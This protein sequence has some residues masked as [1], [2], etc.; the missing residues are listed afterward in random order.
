MDLRS[1]N[2]IENCSLLNYVK[3]CLAIKEN[4]IKLKGHSNHLAQ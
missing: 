1:L 4:V 3:K 2:P